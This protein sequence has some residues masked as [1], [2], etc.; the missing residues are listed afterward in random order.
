LQVGNMRAW[1]LVK[2]KIIA[3]EGG[4]ERGEED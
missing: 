1:F 3:E 4:E 2:R